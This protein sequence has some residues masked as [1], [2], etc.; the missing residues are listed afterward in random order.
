MKRIEFVD[1]TLRDGNQSLWSATGLTTQMILDVAP[2]IERAGF[3]ALDFITSTHMGTAVRWHREDPW[4]RIRRAKEAMPNTPLGF[5]TTGLR[6]ISWVRLAE[7]VIAFA[8][9]LLVKNGIERVWVIDPM[10]DME[11][12]LRSAR[13]AKRAGAREVVVG[14]TYSLSPAHAAELYGEMARALAG[15]EEIDAVYLK[16]PG[17]LLTPESTEAVLKQIRPEI[18]TLPLELHSHCNTGLAPLCYLKA[19]ELGVDRLH[20]ACPP[21]ANGTSQP[22][23]PMT[24]HN[25]RELGFEVRLDDEAVAGTSAHLT[26]VARADGLPEGRPLEYDVTHYRRQVPGG[27]ISTLQRQLAEIRMERRLPE[28]LEEIPRVRADLG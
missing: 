26:G 12:A 10:N 19:A 9:R 3:R 16:D 17:G 18:G 5:L 20:T 22:S 13:L 21:L 27:M 15:A 25:L 23:A 7:D 2:D 28:V 8:M 4:E 1:T 6:F 11:A 14:L 24:A